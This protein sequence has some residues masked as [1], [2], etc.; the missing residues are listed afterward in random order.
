MSTCRLVVVINNTLGVIWGALTCNWF[1]HAFCVP[2][3]PFCDIKLNLLFE[4][5]SQ[6]Q[7]VTVGGIP[8]GDPALPYPRLNGDIVSKVMQ[9][10]LMEIV[11]TP[12]LDTV[13]ISLPSFLCGPVIGGYI[14][15]GMTKHK[16][17]WHVRGDQSAPCLPH[18]YRDRENSEHTQHF[19]TDFMDTLEHLLERLNT[20][21]RIMLQTICYSSQACS[22]LLI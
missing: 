12:N 2:L 15:C 18:H 13:S 5:K 17:C 19:L 6:L 16:V 11:F 9:P 22:L 20:Q 3:L 10:C 7:F 8:R 14:Y 4:G 21:E 1:K